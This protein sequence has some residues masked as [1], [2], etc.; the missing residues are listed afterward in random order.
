MKICLSLFTLSPKAYGDLRSNRFILPCPP[1]LWQNKNRISKKLVIV[2]EMF[3]WM[4][5]ESLNMKIS[6]SGHVWGLMFDEMSIQVSSHCMTHLVTVTYSEVWIRRQWV[7]GMYSKWKALYNDLTI[8]AE[9][10]EVAHIL[11]KD[12]FSILRPTDKTK[13]GAQTMAYFVNGVQIVKEVMISSTG[14]LTIH[15]KGY[16]ICN[17]DFSLGPNVSSLMERDFQCIH[18]MQQCQGYELS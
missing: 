11:M 14:K 7:Q 4:Q 13:K 5:Q 2:S 15:M 17:K 9:K 12:F 1:H 18:Q 8:T 16:T 10:S 6:T 3:A